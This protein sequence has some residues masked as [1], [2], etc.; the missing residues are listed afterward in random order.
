MQ[1][2]PIAKCAGPARKTICDDIVAMA[3]YWE[4][5]S[6]VVSSGRAPAD[7]END[8]YPYSSDMAQ[9]LAEIGISVVVWH[10]YKGLGVKT[11]EPEMQKTAEFFEHCQRYGLNKGVYINAGSVFVDTFFSEN[12]QAKEWIAVDQNQRAH[13]YSEF[14]RCY[15]RWRLCSSYP[16]FGQYIGKAAVKAI[17]EAGATHI[18]FDNSSQMPCYCEKCRS[19]WLG[20]ITE[21]FPHDSDEKPFN[22]KKRFGHDFN[23]TLE[24]PRGT[25][26]MPID[27]LPA[28]YHPGIYEWV[29]WRNQ[30]SENTLKTACQII[31]E[32]NPNTVITWNVA[33]DNGEFARLVWGVDPEASS[34]CNTDFFFS[35]DG[36]YAGIEEGRLIT[37]IRTYK[38]GWAMDNRVLTHN[39][40]KGNQQAQRLNYAEAAAFNRGCLGHVMWA[41]DSDDKQIDNLKSA[42]AF[43]RE[44]K[45]IYLEAR[46]FSRAAV[47]RCSESEVANWADTTVSRFAIEQILLKNNVQYDHI[48][49]DRFDEIN[50]YDLLICCNTVTVADDI[51]AKIGD[52]VRKGGKVLCTELS[53]SFNQYNRRRRF[54]SDMGLKGE[55]DPD[56]GRAVGTSDSSSEIL[57]YLG[58]EKEYIDSIFYISRID[59]ARKFSW[60]PATSQL[61]IIAK[62]Y[63]IEPHNGQRILALVDKALGY[64]QLRVQSP[65][66]VLAGLFEFPDGSKLIHL[67]DYQAGRKLQDVNVEMLSS[68]T[69]KDHAEFITFNASVK[70][71]PTEEAGYLIFELP[72]FMTY[73]FM[74]L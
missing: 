29:R 38:Y 52:F 63:F 1:N 43:F 5:V 62:D 56:L 41:T 24:L 17:K 69:N 20:H 53:F 16:Q 39:M 11:E 35:E 44:H 36:N 37:R 18:H 14:Y 19:D 34:R 48:I 57:D 66:N 33:V 51:I 27:N 28:A 25:S 58:L 54:S 70:I 55:Q 40:P 4:P 7:I 67:L 12:P 30:L 60:S 10:Y 31:R 26:R 47:Y 49:N 15:Y 71:K 13:Q 32:A 45:R 3:G 2:N 68:L 64:R 6:M 65:E 59:Y 21:M 8:E 50:N 42:I 46:P 23:G 73:G 9:K 74:K 22:F 61:P 72:P